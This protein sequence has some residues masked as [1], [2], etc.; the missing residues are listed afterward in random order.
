VR[1]LVLD[2]EPIVGKRLKPAL[3]KSGYE[4]DVVERGADALRLIDE[5]PYDVVVTDVRM[6][7]VDGL[8]VLRHVR[9]HSARTLV[10]MITGYATVDVA[11]DALTHGAFDFIAKPFKLDDLRAAIARA[12]ARL[13][14]GP[15]Q[16]AGKPPS[17]G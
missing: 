9:Q 17:E 5:R 6:E 1:I 16:A 10:I 7:G 8:D 12:V 15:A 2:D 14:E 11:R 13:E 4:V 3:E